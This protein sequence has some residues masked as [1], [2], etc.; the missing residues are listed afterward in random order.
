MVKLDFTKP[1]NGYVPPQPSR[2]SRL[3]ARA[4]GTVFWFFTFFRAKQDLPHRL[5]SHFEE[6]NESEDEEELE[7][8]E[9]VQG[10]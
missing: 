4:M 7:G 2:S 1:Y 10:R 3:M 9:Q 5:R 8:E 6:Q